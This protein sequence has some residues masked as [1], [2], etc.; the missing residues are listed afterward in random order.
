[1][2]AYVRNNP[3]RYTDPSGRCIPGVNCPWGASETGGIVQVEKTYACGTL[4][5]CHGSPSRNWRGTTKVLP[6]FEDHE[7][8]NELE[9][10]N[11][12]KAVHQ[13]LKTESTVRAWPGTELGYV[14]GY[15]AGRG[16]YDT[17]FWNGYEEDTVI[18]IQ[19]HGCYQRSH[20]NYI[21]Q[22]MWGA[23][24]GETTGE[25][26]E[27]VEWWNQ[28]MYGHPADPD[29]LYWAEVGS[30]WEME[31]LRQEMQEWLEE[32]TEASEILGLYPP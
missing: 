26:L 20:V 27:V 21:A 9:F 8:I 28:Y 1:R 12:F 13:D 17:P 25:T 10:N 30:K 24:G 29:E 18:C 5:E 2:Y 22:G 14:F 16:V 15:L 19:G 32:L 23:R 6:R 11:L 7:F 4:A 3:L 31:R